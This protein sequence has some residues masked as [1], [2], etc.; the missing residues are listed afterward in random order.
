MRLNI[1][2]DLGL[3]T[4]FLR[5]AH[6]SG[7]P[8]LRRSTDSRKFDNHE[9]VHRASDLPSALQGNKCLISHFLASLRAQENW[10]C[11]HIAHQCCDQS[12]AV[13]TGYPLTSMTRPYRGFSFDPSR[14]STFLKLSA[15]KLL[16]FK[17]SPAQVWFFFIYMKY[18]LF[19]CRT[20][21][22]LISNWPRTRKFSQLL[23]AG[24]TVAFDFSH[25]GHALVT[26]YVQFLFSD[27]SKFDGWERTTYAA[28][29]NL[30]TLTTEAD[31][32]LCQLVMFLT[33]FF[34][35][36]YKKWNSAAI[37]S[38]L[39]FVASLFN[40]FLVEKYVACQSRKS[41]LGWHRFRFSPCLMRERVKKSAVTW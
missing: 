39:L 25:H 41:D 38:L 9:T 36:I 10:H 18:V 7:A 27:L 17:W 20:I 22:I 33:V 6:A 21:K 31:R 35:W 19:M 3:Q 32:V 15:D 26:L 29:W 37:K 24:K 34:R 8:L 40:G 5:E 28:S 4:K 13:K 23:Q 1:D 2:R 30:F 12:T 11:T 16:V 14:S